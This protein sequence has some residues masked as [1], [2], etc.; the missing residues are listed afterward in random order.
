[1]R[2][3]YAPSAIV[4][5]LF[6]TAFAVAADVE[7]L[8]PEEAVK[9]GSP[10]VSGLNNLADLPLKIDPDL[11]KLTG[12]KAHDR[13]AI[14][15][16]TRGLTADVIAKADKEVVP[17]GY[18]VLRGITPIVASQQIARDEHRMLSLTVG[19]KS[20]EVAVIQLGVAKV[21]GRPVLVGYTKTGTPAFVTTLV[22]SGIAGDYP[23]DLE[24][25]SAGEG[26]ATVT[27]T[28]GGKYRASLDVAAQD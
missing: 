3:Y 23:L 22:D 6:L 11:D 9:V 16:P 27:L 10:I 28:L 17:V 2:P 12:L 24:A 7:R 26:R 14:V 5:A 1:M 4:V 13:G 18:V 19:D 15:L 25:T 21:A 8:T 20:A